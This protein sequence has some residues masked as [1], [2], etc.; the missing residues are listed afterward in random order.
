MESAYL[1]VCQ[2]YT[3]DHDDSTVPGIEV[4]VYPVN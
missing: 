2:F 4:I 3:R 1:V